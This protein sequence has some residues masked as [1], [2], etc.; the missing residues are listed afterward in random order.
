MRSVVLL[1]LS[2]LVAGACSG[3]GGRSTVPGGFLSEA[4]ASDTERLMT[5]FQKNDF[6]TGWIRPGK[7]FWVTH[8]EMPGKVILEVQDKTKSLRAATVYQRKEGA[9]PDPET[10]TRVNLI[11]FKGYVK[12]YLD[13]EGDFWTE[14]FYPFRKGL[15]EE[16][17][18]VFTRQF[19]RF[20]QEA[21]TIM[22]DYLR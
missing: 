14:M 19:A 7:V 15:V 3:G 8:D 20:S 21:A 2:A 16:G 9:T 22:A 10:H 11:N 12:V 1:F 6:S 18:M 13:D 17:L 5:L 4:G